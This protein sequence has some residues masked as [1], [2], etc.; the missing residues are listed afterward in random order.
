MG[1]WKFYRFDFQSS[2]GQDNQSPTASY[3]WEGSVWSKRSVADRPL[4]L[5]D[6]SGRLFMQIDTVSTQLGANDTT[7][8][9][10]N[11]LG[12]SIPD[13]STGTIGGKFDSSTL[14]AFAVVAAFGDA[15]I[16]SVNISSTFAESIPSMRLRYDN[17]TTKAGYCTVLVSFKTDNG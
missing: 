3:K 9:D 5:T 12:A 4:D 2:T 15:L 6:K 1:A 16:K 11:V 13:A 8:A 14:G 7:S 10:I 17:N